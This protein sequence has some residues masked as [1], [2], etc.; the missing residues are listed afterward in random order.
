MEALTWPGDH[1]NG[2]DDDVGPSSLYIPFLNNKSLLVS[3]GTGMYCPFGQSRGGE[4][5]NPAVA[6]PHVRAVSLDIVT[7]KPDLSRWISLF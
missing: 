1:P 4:R 2:S 6:F 5:S 7:S 3:V